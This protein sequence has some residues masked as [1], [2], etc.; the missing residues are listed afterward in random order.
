MTTTPFIRLLYAFFKIAGFIMIGSGMLSGQYRPLELPKSWKFEQAT[1]AYAPDQPTQKL[2]DFQPGLQVDVLRVEPKSGKWEVQF[3]RYGSLDIISLI[4][5]PNL[6][7]VDPSGFSRIKELIEE[8]PLLK[9]QLEAAD[10]WPEDSRELVRRLFGAADAYSVTS[11]TEKAPKVVRLKSAAELS[12]FWGITPLA[13]YLDCSNSDSPKLVI[14]VWN[15]GDAFQSSVDPTHAAR[16]IAANLQSIQSVF[17]T[18]RTDSG[19]S[20][21]ASAITA[22][23]M[24]EEV[25]L[26]PNDLRLS[27]RYNSGEYLILEMESVGRLAAQAPLV[28]QP[29]Q[30]DALMA[31]RVKRSEHGHIY[32]SQIPMIDQGEKG[33]CAAATVARVLQ[34]YGYPVDVHALADLAE[35]EAQYSEY[36]RGGTLRKN[37]ISAMRRICSSTPFRLKEITKAHPDTIRPIIEQ[38]VPILWFV[39]GHARLLIGIHP[40]NNE[41]VFSDTWGPEYAYQVGTWEYFHNMNQEMWVFLPQ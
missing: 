32:V 26:L 39:P 31:S 7:L 24:H 21:A 4:D 16:E 20:S 41:V 14:E 30:F 37:L 36:D 25:S 12:R 22:V 28:Y 27:L 10:P 1:P 35:T 38:G 33:Y 5:P 17:R 18:T 19:A 11:G 29:D 15:K 2:G 40:E 23:R 6:S 9:K 3:K 8:F 13:V 34:Y